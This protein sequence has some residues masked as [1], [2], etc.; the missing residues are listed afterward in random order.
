MNKGL[1]AIETASRDEIVALQTEPP[2]AV[3]R[4][5]CA[6]VGAGSA[7]ATGI[8]AHRAR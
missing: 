3:L 2:G 1:H 4:A 8:G 6:M 7:G 5:W